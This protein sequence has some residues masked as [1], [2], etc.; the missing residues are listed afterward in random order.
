MKKVLKIGGL[1]AGGLFLAVIILGVVLQLTGWEPPEEK[2][3]P[4]PVEKVNQPESD[5]D[6][7]PEPQPVQTPEP[8]PDP[9]PQPEP[10]KSD[11]EL[12]LEKVV[13]KVHATTLV[14]EYTDN[15]FA[16]DEKYK[17]KMVMVRGE[18]TQFG[19]TFGK[20][21]VSLKS[22]V[23]LKGLTCYVQKNQK[24]ILAQLKIGDDVL[25]IGKVEDISLSIVDIEECLI[26]RTPKESK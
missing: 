14:Q 19:E 24:P 1:S 3:K 12:A 7:D 10:P 2:E 4:I 18:I 11:F 23:L 15:K 9:E 17:G 6:P 22:N 13:H 25:V 26:I 8:T 21:R 5:P 16:A 20:P